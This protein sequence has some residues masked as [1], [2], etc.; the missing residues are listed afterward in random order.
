M[1]RLLIMC[2]AIVLIGAEDKLW[3]SCDSSCKTGTIVKLLVPEHGLPIGQLTQ[4]V[5][6]SD[7][8]LVRIEDPTPLERG[9]LWIS[10]EELGR[11]PLWEAIEAREKKTKKISSSTRPRFAETSVHFGGN[12][13]EEESGPE[14]DY[15]SPYFK[16]DKYKFTYFDYDNFGTSPSQID[17][18][19]MEKATKEVMKR[20]SGRQVT[21]SNSALSLMR[22]AMQEE[23]DADEKAEKLAEL[24]A[25][26]EL[27]EIHKCTFRCQK[28]TARARMLPHGTTHQLCFS[29]EDNDKWKKLYKASKISAVAEAIMYVR[30]NY[31][32]VQPFKNIQGYLVHNNSRQFKSSNSFHVIR[33]SETVMASHNNYVDFERDILTLNNITFPNK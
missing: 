10:R 2:C 6:M 7:G 12:D 27:K 19:R 29:K 8:S 15:M 3:L 21:L 18:L 9:D 24:Q 28:K 26:M 17:K 13:N 4:I 30:K 33:V 14:D 32:C 23:K 11:N 25:K 31:P 5:E 22:N 16:R 1:M 20:G